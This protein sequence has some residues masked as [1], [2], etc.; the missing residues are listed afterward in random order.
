[1]GTIT[2]FQSSK[3]LAHGGTP[4]VRWRGEEGV[5]VLL[6]LCSRPS[7]SQN[8]LFVPLFLVQI[9]CSPK[10]LGGLLRTVPTNS[11]LFL[12]GLLNMREMQILTSVIEI[13]K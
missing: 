12:R 6:S 11:K 5:G 3:N 4:R 10:L 1:M 13:K 7:F 9:F 8:F 2:C